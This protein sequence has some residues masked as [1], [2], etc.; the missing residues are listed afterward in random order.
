MPHSHALVIRQVEIVHEGRNGPPL[1]KECHIVD[2]TASFH[3]E[4]G[5]QQ[6]F[7][8][9]ETTPGADST[10]LLPSPLPCTPRLLSHVSGL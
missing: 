4:G 2:L 1:L 9:T 8:D 7:L 3:V 10:K 5:T 6:K